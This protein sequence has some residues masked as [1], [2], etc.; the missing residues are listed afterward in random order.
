MS[1]N[2]ARVIHHFSTLLFTETVTVC[3]IL[4]MSTVAKFPQP[5][6]IQSVVAGEIRAWMGRRGVT[7]TALAETLGLSQ[8][9]I[10]KRLRGTIPLDIVELKKI[11]DFLGVDVAT[12]VGGA[13]TTGP[14]PP[15]RPS[16]PTQPYVAHLAA[17]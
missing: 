4:C 14:N 11:A 15:G 17:A 6:D 12:L 10:S 2:T 5:G 7:Q 13:P 9:Q 3:I 1:S 8:S 16:A